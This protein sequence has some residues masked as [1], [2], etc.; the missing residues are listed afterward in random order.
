MLCFESVLDGQRKDQRL[1]QHSTDTTEPKFV[2]TLAIERHANEIYT[3]KIFLEV[4]KEILKC[5]NLCYICD[6]GEVVGDLHTYD[7]AHQDHTKDIVNEFKVS[8]DYI[9]YNVHMCIM[10]Y[11]NIIFL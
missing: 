3:R 9:I 6:R 10:I 7:I 11:Y 1:L 4:Q 8:F 2:T 5:M